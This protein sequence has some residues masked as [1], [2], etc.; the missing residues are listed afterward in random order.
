MVLLLVDVCVLLV[1]YAAVLC[2]GSSQSGISLR[3]E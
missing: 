1:Q 3:D 2:L